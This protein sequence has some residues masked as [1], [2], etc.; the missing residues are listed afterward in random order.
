[1]NTHKLTLELSETIFKQLTTLA[2]Q[3][4][5][6]L[7]S[8][9]LDTIVSYL[10]EAKS[11]E[12]TLQQ[13]QN[14]SQV[15]LLKITQETLDDSHISRHEHLLECNQKGTITPQERLELQDLRLKADRLM[16]RKAY[17]WDILGTKGYMMLKLDE[18]ALFTISQE[19]GEGTTI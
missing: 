18:I 14:Y 7:E 2:N 17:A 15:Q 4:Q 10:S 12:S 3:N 8:L 19:K 6:S 1:M 16:L 13:M 11:Q 5:S 9:T